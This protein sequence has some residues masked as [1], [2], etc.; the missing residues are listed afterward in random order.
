MN[1]LAG[2]LSDLE[3]VRWPEQAWKIGVGRL[4]VPLGKS[5]LETLKGEEAVASDTD[6]T[7]VRK[8][9]AKDQGIAS[10]EADE[11]A[12][13]SLMRNHGLFSKGERALQI[14]GWSERARSDVEIF[15]I[16]AS[17]GLT[18]LLMVLS[19]AHAPAKSA[20]AP[21][22]ETLNLPLRRSPGALE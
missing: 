19:D 1:Q 2:V 20:A 21:A 16:V 5:E 6:L 10:K 17:E 8:K 4:K 14:A 11:V 12:A 22:A 3:L 7:A 9:W 18:P 15:V 13:R